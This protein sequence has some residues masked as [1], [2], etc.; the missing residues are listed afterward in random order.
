[1]QGMISAL[2]VEGAGLFLVL[3]AKRGEANVLYAKK[4]S[5]VTT[6]DGIE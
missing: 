1:M 6:T 5:Y 4:K 3:Q 2:R